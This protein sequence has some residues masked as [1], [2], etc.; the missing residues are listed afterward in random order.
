MADQVAVAEPVA[1]LAPVD[2]QPNQHVGNTDTSRTVEK[3]PEADLLS[4]VSQ[5]RKNEPA[6]TE[7]Q[8]F[9]DYKQIEAITDPVA[10][11]IAVKA[12]K[13][14]QAGLTQKTQAIAEE[15]RKLEQKLQE[16]T[17]WSP[18]R[19]QRELLSNPQFVQAAQQIA[20][21][22]PQNPQNSGLTNEEFSAL[23]DREKADFSSL[24]QEIN[25]LKNNNYQARIQQEDAMLQQKYA[26]YN[27]DQINN[28]WND[29]STGKIQAT[30]EHLYII[31]NHKQQ[32]Q[33]AYEL[34]KQEV[35]QLNQT[36][37][38]GSSING[39]QVNDAIG[40]PVKDKGETDQSFFVKL[41][42]FRLAQ[43]KK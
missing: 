38:N 21:T 43:A 1:P 23:T 25:V 31:A 22:T 2:V 9:F 37:A 13:S 26:D 5:F 30:R 33:A 20:A 6:K 3:A 4:K 34:G 35:S 27:P 40:I 41:A 19:I 24:K 10:K 15:R 14:M 17:N 8:D 16:T 7:T 29:L 18:E 12:Y 36:R 42:R 39:M 32:L 28:L 11:D